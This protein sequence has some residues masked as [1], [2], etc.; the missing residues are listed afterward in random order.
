MENGLRF[1]RFEIDLEAQEL[2]RSGQRV[3]LQPR[4]F[5]ILALLA[6]RSGS[7]V[8]RQEIR[9]HVWG[10]DTWVDFDHNVS[11]CLH[12]IRV[13]LND[14]GPTPRFVETLPRRGYRFL[15]PV[16]RGAAIPA[17]EGKLSPL[18]PGSRRGQRWAA[19]AALVLLTVGVAVGWEQARPAAAVPTSAAQAAYLKGLYLRKSGSARL[20]DAA[21]A[22]EDAV[23]L[24]PARAEAHAALA[25]AYV[26]IA[27]L[28]LRPARAT[29]ALAEDQAR[30]ALR[31]DPSRATAHVALGTARLAGAWDWEGARASFARAL[32]LDDRLVAAHASW[33]AY[34]SARGDHAGAIA[35]IRR[36]QALDPVCLL[37]RGDA[38]W[39]YYCARRFGD[40]ATEWRKAVAIDPGQ[41]GGHERLVR[42]YRHA[43]RIDEA[44]EAAR[45]TM[46]LAG[47]ADVQ[48]VDLTLFSKGT[49][50]WLQT[51]PAPGPDALERRAALHASVGERGRALEA[52]ETA[53]DRRSRFLLRYLAADPDFDVLRGDPRY[54]SLLRRVGLAG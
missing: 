12:Q 26:E 53:C 30:E 28:G 1:G 54:R 14:R 18:H 13:A 9:Q 23:R 42:A 3:K 35:A 2:R 4:P 29:L 50:R 34:L 48:R 6:S 21:R 33:A 17:G 51:S 41:A 46:R 32:A 22:F 24:D 44:L 45:E 11:F 37:V 10:S 25:E 52:L 16:E 15:T 20:E 19:A 49:A 38:G 43:G 39:Y 36:A 47:V 5:R 7:L 27:D 40:A 8:T 31:L